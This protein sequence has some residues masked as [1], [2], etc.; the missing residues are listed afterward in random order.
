MNNKLYKMSDERSPLISSLSEEEILA[1]EIGLKLLGISVSDDFLDIPEMSLHKS[2]KDGLYYEIPYYNSEQLYT[3]DNQRMLIVVYSFTDGS[4][5]CPLRIDFKYI[6]KEN[7]T[8][9]WLYVYDQSGQKTRKWELVAHENGRSYTM[10]PEHS[11]IK[12]S[13]LIGYEHSD[14]T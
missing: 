6:N 11:T 4:Y 5:C 2:E 10:I 9:Y 12:L 1:Y 7:E 14:L 3:Q 8:D 13:E